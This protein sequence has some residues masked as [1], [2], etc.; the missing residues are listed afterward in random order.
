MP[1]AVLDRLKAALS[2]R[3]AIEREIGSG[4]MATVYLAHDI[5]HERQG[6]F[7]DAGRAQ[8]MLMFKVKVRIGQ[9]RKLPNGMKANEI[10]A[11]FNHIRA[12]LQPFNVAVKVS[13]F[14]LLFECSISFEQ[15]IMRCQRRP[16]TDEHSK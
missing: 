10:A 13:P 4:G 9:N 5:R 3:Y 7:T 11:S 1:D 14:G 6:R 8:N 12:R 2:D 15:T 16:Y